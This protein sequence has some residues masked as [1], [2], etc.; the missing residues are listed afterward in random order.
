MS[1]TISKHGFNKLTAELHDLQAVQRP[2]ILRIVAAAR[3]LGDLSENAEY[4]SSRERQR[5]IDRRIGFLE[6]IITTAQVIDTDNLS[7]DRVIFGATVLAE[8]EDGNNLQCRIL[9]DLEADGKITI[10]CTSPLGRAMI[11]KCVGDTCTV[12]TPS[13]E[14]EW[15]ILEIK[16]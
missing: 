4:T 12:Q 2:E 5:A 9:S 1:R 11:G 7:G 15:E 10:A 16:F 6:E 8:D 14:K 13:G 3:A